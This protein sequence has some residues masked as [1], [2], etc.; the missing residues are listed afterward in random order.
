MAHVQ[1]ESLLPLS[2]TGRSVDARP[3]LLIVGARGINGHEGGVEKFAEEFGRRIC[4]GCK[5]TFL[6]LLDGKPADFGDA[7]IIVA[8]RSKTLS[9]DKIYYY[10]L[11]L[12]IGLTRRFDHIML[13]GLNSAMLL[14]PLRLAFWRRTRIVIRSGSID[15]LLPKWGLLSRLY[16]RAAE[17]LLRFADRVVAVAPS[18][19]RHLATRGIRSVV[20][21][22]GLRTGSSPISPAVRER[23]QVLAVGRVTP[24]KNYGL[25]I[26]AARLLSD[27]GV[28]IDIIGGADLSEERRRLDAVMAALDVGN[29]N[30]RGAMHRDAVM[31]HIAGASLFVNCSIH[32]GMSNSVLEAIQQG[33]PLILSGIAANR[34]LDLPDAFYFDPG[35]A[36]ELAARI[37]AALAAPSDFVVDP[38]RFKD[39]D[40][41]VEAYRAFMRLPRAQPALATAPATLA[42]A[43]TPADI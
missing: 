40:E 41:T 27:R 9:T 13:L 4:G 26:E 32:E 39:W 30:F 24:Q 17:G 33:A 16:F 19:Q 36:A 12:W 10:M 43:T 6:C 1:T 31:E 5:V 21:P 25:L 11:A 35:S 34:D 20:I 28:T 15:Y 38:A 42:P 2:T 23:R 37:E 7:E 29:V 18:I 8:P 14:L 22:N 3:R